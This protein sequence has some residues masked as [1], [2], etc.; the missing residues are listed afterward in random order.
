MRRTAS[1]T[2]AP[3]Y[4]RMTTKSNLLLCEMISSVASCGTMR[5]ACSL[6]DT[7]NTVNS[8]N[9]TGGKWAY[10]CSGGQQTFLVGGQ[11]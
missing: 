5:Y 10:M 2:S 6:A 1:R 4:W 9:P 3:W 11:V 7:N 8:A